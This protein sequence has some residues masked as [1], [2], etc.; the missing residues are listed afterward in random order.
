MST[1]TATRPVPT[2]ENPLASGWV[3]QSTIPATMLSDVAVSKATTQTQRKL[4]R[5]IVRSED[6]A[7]RSMGDLSPQTQRSIERLKDLKLV[8]V[9]KA[10]GIAA[11]KA[12]EGFVERSPA[13]V[14]RTAKPKASA[15]AKTGTKAA[16]KAATKAKPAAKRVVRR[17]V[18]KGA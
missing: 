17:S 7:P 8:T 14:I 2:I 6:G 5:A 10:G 3:R 11:T 9:S 13:P 12:G 4:L 16:T 18:K 15:K 1:A